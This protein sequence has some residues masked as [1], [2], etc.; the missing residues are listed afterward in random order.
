[1]PYNLSHLLLEWKVSFY[2]NCNSKAYYF[3]CINTR[4][5]DKS[6][7]MVNF[8]Y[9]TDIRYQCIYYRDVASTRWV[10]GKIR[11]RMT[12]EGFNIC[13]FIENKICYAIFYYFSGWN[14]LLVLRIYIIHQVLTTQV[15]KLTYTREYE[16][17]RIFIR[18]ILCLHA[19]IR[20]QKFGHSIYTVLYDTT[21]VEIQRLCGRKTQ[22]MS[23]HNLV[24]NLYYWCVCFAVYTV[25]NEF[26][27]DIIRN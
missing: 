8:P 23:I 18:M 17:G 14:K 12:G 1:M 15:I 27:S 21:L 24:T 26:S 19:Y 3:F 20:C 7:Y 9:I 16:T 6:S 13:I 25:T 5:E 11:N 2:C 22:R 10:A 4:G